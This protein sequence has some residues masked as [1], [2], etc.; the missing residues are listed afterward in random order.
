MTIGLPNIFLAFLFFYLILFAQSPS[1]Y[2]EY[3][4]NNLVYI[5]FP[6][7]WLDSCLVFSFII[8]RYFGG[9]YF[10]IV[11]NKSLI[12][13]L[14]ILI[15]FSLLTSKHWIRLSIKLIVWPSERSAYLDDIITIGLPRPLLTL[16]RICTCS[17]L[18]ASAAYI[19]SY[20]YLCPVL[21]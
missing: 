3:L 5:P 17:F 1:N 2:R 9:S 6:T 18:Y 19:N 4:G 20:L 11:F 7:Y 21:K 14:L 13:V 16:S 15:L 8:I 12:S 10:G